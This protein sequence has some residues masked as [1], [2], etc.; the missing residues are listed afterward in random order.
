MQGGDFVTLALGREVFAVPVSHVREILDYEP[1]FRI[2]EGPAWLLGL[3]DVRG[4]GTPVIDLRTKLGLPAVPPDG[5]T[6]ILVLDV[7]LGGRSLGLGLVA[8]RVIEVAQFAAADIEAA[9]EIGVKWRS[10]Y[11]AGIVRRTE[12]FVVLFDLVALF[13]GAETALAAADHAL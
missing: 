7:E 1:A 2:P 3:I 9:P 5:A 6:R 8:D 4:R 11:I 12:G 13:A 10:S